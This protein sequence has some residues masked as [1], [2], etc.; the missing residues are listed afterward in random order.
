MDIQSVRLKKLKAWILSTSACLHGKKTKPTMLRLPAIHQRLL[1]AEE[2]VLNYRIDGRGAD[3]ECRLMKTIVS[4]KCMLCFPRK[5]AIRQ[6][7]KGENC[8]LFL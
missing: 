7:E 4:L 5:R 2:F 8:H 6:I 1:A 3:E